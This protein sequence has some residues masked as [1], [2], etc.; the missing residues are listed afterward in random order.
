MH[1]KRVCRQHGEVLSQCRCPSPS[2]ATTYVMCDDRC[3]KNTVNQVEP[4]A[5]L[6]EE[7]RSRAATYADPYNGSDEWEIFKEIEELASLAKQRRG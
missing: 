2:K 1:Q 4:Q 5:D 6:L 7:I 3:P